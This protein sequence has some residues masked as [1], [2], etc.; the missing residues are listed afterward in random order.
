MTL[1]CSYG[2]FSYFVHEYSY[3]SSNSI[4]TIEK[5]CLPTGSHISRSSEAV[6]VCAHKKTPC[7]YMKKLIISLFRY[8]VQLR[9][10]RK[11]YVEL[12]LTVQPVI[13]ADIV[14]N[15]QQ[16]SNLRRCSIFFLK[17]CL[18][19]R[20]RILITPGIAFNVQP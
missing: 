13:F 1:R 11:R 9:K 2:A 5:G 19:Y 17:H 16:L 18:V 14:N 12:G 7:S 20:H 15:I 10:K 6:K 8:R 3:F 4:V